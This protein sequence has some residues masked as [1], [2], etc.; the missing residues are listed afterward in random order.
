[1]GNKKIYNLSTKIILMFLAL[2][3]LVS[4]AM[5][6]AV[7]NV[8]Y[9][10]VLDEY[11]CIAVNCGSYIAQL[12]GGESTER[13]LENGVDDEYLKIEEN[14]RNIKS[15]YNLEYL[16]ISSPCFN[17]NGEMINDMIYIFDVMIEGEDPA[18]FGSLG[19]HTGEVDVYQYLYQIYHTG[20][21][22]KFDIIT[23][24][25]FGSL[26]SAYVPVFAD[27]GTVCAMVG[28][29]IDMVEIL[30]NVRAE[31]IR[32]VAVL[33][34]LVSIFAII[35][36]LYMRKNIVE[37]VNT[38]S[39]HM[40]RFVTE[41][42]DLE[43]RPVRTIS[44]K[45]EIEQMAHDFNSMAQAIIDYT[46]NLERTTVEKE[47]M[48]ADLDVAAHI[49]ASISTE[50]TYPAFPDRNDFELYAS[51]K[52]TVF[53]KCSFCNYF[54]TDEN[55]L[56]IIVGESAGRSLSS[57]LV[58]ILASTNI[59][60]FAKMG[61]QPYRIAI[62]TNNQLSNVEKNDKE[63]S[64]G[65]IIAEIDLKTGIMRYVNAGMPPIL[66]KKVG[67]SFDFETAAVQFTIGE[68]KGVSFTQET[69]Q[70]RQG[71][72]VMFTSN[73]VP[74]MKNTYKV[75]FTEERI[76]SEINSIAGG[77]YDLK[78]IVDSFEEKLDRFREN[79]PVEQDTTI[80]AFRYFG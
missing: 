39:E 75:Q 67:E 61:Y 16:Y 11:N 40:N 50:I 51:L 76:K 77:V 62:E 22:V 53:N 71:N 32:I 34:L 72:T 54:M 46:S 15:I 31:T 70:L 57:M 69:I 60:C 73:G 4:V 6:A 59:Q 33:A 44:T 2:L 68:M 10:R 18:M 17:E 8:N 13:W 19:E 64:V 79:E 80:L 42:A 78:E 26:L 20:E 63:L 65:A 23:E 1:M 35:F 3:V 52:N 24:S 25:K 37:P 12:I 55:H 43:Y 56:Y 36:I 9:E 38:L 7:Y 47:R 49:R 74:E 21:I 41:G 66:I 45:D 48:R 14:L 27:D 28:V 29:D 5:G 58:A 30:A